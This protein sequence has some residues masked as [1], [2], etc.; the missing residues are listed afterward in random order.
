V[1]T[2]SLFATV[3]YFTIVLALQTHIRISLELILCM[4][5]SF[6][7][8]WFVGCCNDD[9]DIINFFP[10]LAALHFKFRKFAVH[11]II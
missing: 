10:N 7:F 5:I 8:I 2:T 6:F 1:A 11:C 3:I 9:Y 4:V